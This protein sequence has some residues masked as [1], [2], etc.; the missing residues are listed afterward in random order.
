VAGAPKPARSAGPLGSLAG[1]TVASVTAASP[2]GLSPSMAP[3][4]APLW[5]S[6]PL[7]QGKEA[8]PLPCVDV[9]AEEGFGHLLTR[10]P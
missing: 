7:S 9:Y 5:P 1:D 3:Q 2:S 6:E 4:A 8:Q 10:P